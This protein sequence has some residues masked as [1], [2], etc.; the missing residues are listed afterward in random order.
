M[1]NQTKTN[2]KN[3]LPFLHSHNFSLYLHFVPFDFLSMLVCKL[4]QISQM[5]IQITLPMTNFATVTNVFCSIVA[6]PHSIFDWI[7]FYFFFSSSSVVVIVIR[8]FFFFS[9]AFSLSPFFRFDQIEQRINN[10]YAFGEMFLK[11]M[12]LM[13]RTKTLKTE[14]LSTHLFIINH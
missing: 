5:A 11:W 4:L 8:W 9:F 7:S 6:D 14:N 13:N 1:E 10:Q 3:S 2:K 12:K